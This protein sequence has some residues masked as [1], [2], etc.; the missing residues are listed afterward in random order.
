MTKCSQGCEGQGPLGEGVD[1]RVRGESFLS[2]LNTLVVILGRGQG[3]GGDCPSWANIPS[4]IL[5]SPRIWSW[6]EPQQLCFPVVPLSPGKTGSWDGTRL[7]VP[8]ASVS[9]SSDSS[10][11]I[12]LPPGQCVAASAPHQLGKYWGRGERRPP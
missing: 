6:T 1:Q 11:W 9:W 10:L 8:L 7:E 4:E 3:G 5:L 2:S 12:H